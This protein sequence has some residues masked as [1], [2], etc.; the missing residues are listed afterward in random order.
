M[1]SKFY[2]SPSVLFCSDQIEDSTNWIIKNLET[3]TSLHQMALPMMRCCPDKPF[4][5]GIL[6]IEMHWLCRAYKCHGW[7]TN[8]PENAGCAWSYGGPESL[9]HI[10]YTPWAENRTAYLAS[11]DKDQHSKFKVYFLLNVHWFYTITES[12][13]CTSSHHEAGMASLPYWSLPWSSLI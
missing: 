1:Q 9:V 5:E 10:Y 4:K 11:L 2:F 3:K 6:H 7:V 13:L 12:K 8:K